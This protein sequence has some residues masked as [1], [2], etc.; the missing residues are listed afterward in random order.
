[1]SDDGW[2]TVFGISL[3]DRYPDWRTCARLPHVEVPVVGAHAETPHGPLQVVQYFM[4]HDASP[5]MQ[6]LVEAMLR[7]DARIMRLL[8]TCSTAP[9]PLIVFRIQ[10]QVHGANFDASMASRGVF[11]GFHSLCN[12]MGELGHH[13]LSCAFTPLKD[14]INRQPL[15]GTQAIVPPVEAWKMPLLPRQKESLLWMQCFEAMERNSV[16]C[17]LTFHIT[18]TSYS[19]CYF[20]N[21]IVP[22]ELVASTSHPRIGVFGGILA[23]KTGTGK[24]AVTLALIASSP[25]RL[26][27]LD[28]LMHMTAARNNGCMQQA[29]TRGWH[30]VATH[31]PTHASLI[32]VPHNLSKQWMSE[33]DK[34]LVPGALRVVKVFNKRDFD[35]TSMKAA[36]DADV[37]ITTLHFL[38]G[39][40]YRKY[41]NERDPVVLHRLYGTHARLNTL[42][43][44]LPLFF[45]A[46][47]WR[48]VIYDEHHEVV[49]QQQQRSSMNLLNNLK[50]EV[51]WGL[52]A[53]PVLERHNSIFHLD[54]RDAPL[55][56]LFD[57]Q[58]I[59][60]AVRQTIAHHERAAVVV[61]EHIIPINDQERGMLEAYRQRGLEALIQL[62]TCFNV[63]ALFGAPDEDSMIVS[64]TFEEL[65]RMMV[66]KHTNELTTVTSELVALQQ[67]TEVL[68]TRL[69][70]VQAESGS[71]GRT[72]LA[73]GIQRQLNATTRQAERKETEVHGLTLQRDFFQR[74]LRA[75]ASAEDVCPICLDARVNVLTNC[76]HWFC[77]PCVTSYFRNSEHHAP[78]MVCKRP[79]KSGEYFEIASPPPPAEQEGR[80]GPDLQ[81][82]YGSKLAAIV[83]LLRDI[84]SR[85]ERAIMFVQWTALMKIV[86]HLLCDG[87]L[88]ACALF[89]N[90]NVINAALHKFEH[91][92]ADVLLLSLEASTAGLNLVQANHVIFAHALVNVGYT[93]RQNMVDQA[94]GRVNRLGQTKDV[95]VHWFITE[96]TDEHNVY[97]SY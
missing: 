77:K 52:T 30:E 79:L 14:C 80:R 78:C 65:A 64:M 50:G 47:F 83:M 29:L 89:G 37:V 90:S 96:G 33:M 38:Q 9:P 57:K 21:S 46:F 71:E 88:V 36:V 60:L 73:R 48:R 87:G 1:M 11:P 66:T 41:V 54:I 93:W 40:V 69:N 67:Y 10:V 4:R 17:P 56:P 86:R 59:H 68:Q 20:N 28:N 82:L 8:L 25:R 81:Q 15:D 3:V 26:S 22:R 16:E 97:Q 2:N 63:A 24:T 43:D 6:R 85:G 34:F 44:Q 58:L 74:Q 84:K 18:G 92:E 76:G 32:V 31:V 94:V 39:P 13:Y 27:L 5:F 49:E 23:D 7:V 70:E 95:H 62:S 55:F 51:Y 35:A 12:W 72:S 53:T 45:Q 42:G 91:G 75:Q 61:H 19:F